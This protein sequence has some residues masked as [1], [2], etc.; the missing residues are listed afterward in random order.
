MQVFATLIIG[1]KDYSRWGVGKIHG[2]G[3]HISPSGYFKTAK[4]AMQ[5]VDDNIIENPQND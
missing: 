3:K 1:D 4:E 2:S 5:W